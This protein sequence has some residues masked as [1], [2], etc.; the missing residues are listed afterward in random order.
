VTEAAPKPKALIGLTGGIA[1]GKSTVA[2]QLA[3][4]GVVVVD[5]DALAREV[6][7]KGTPGLEE[8]VRL[9]GPPVLTEAGELNRE[10]MGALVFNDPQARQRLNQITHPRIGQLSAERIAQAQGS[11]SPYIVYEAALLVETGAHKGMSALI[12]VAAPAEVQLDRIQR[13]D[14]LSK[15]AA[16]ARLAAQFPLDKKLKVADYVIHNAGDLASLEEQ[17]AR[18]H[19]Q[20]LERFGLVGQ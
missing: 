10:R 5:A 15:E 2:R 19:A 4:L 1:S 17:T 6:V 12:V 11:S 18:V 14:H 8:I 7:A 3:R 16:E 20:L 13:R 9:F